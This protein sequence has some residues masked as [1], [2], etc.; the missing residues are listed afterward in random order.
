MKNR[1]FD[2]AAMAANIASGGNTARALLESCIQHIEA[3]DAQVN[4]FTEKT[5][6]RA[7]AEADAVD[8]RRAKGETLGPLAGVPYAVKNLFDIEG[9]VTLAGSTINRSHAAQAYRLP[10]AGGSL[11]HDL[12]NGA[13]VVWLFVL[14]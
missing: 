14:V 6:H 11:W 1:V 10:E 12:E 2:A 8:A 4:A 7:F 9:L 3:T 13:A 5:L